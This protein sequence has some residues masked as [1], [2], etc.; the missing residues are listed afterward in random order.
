[1]RN[2]SLRSLK[3]SNNLQHLTNVYG[4]KAEIISLPFWILSALSL[5][6]MSDFTPSDSTDNMMRLS[7]EVSKDMVKVNEQ[8]NWS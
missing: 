8:V 2:L 1:M 5:N 4:D 6:S 3:V 7:N